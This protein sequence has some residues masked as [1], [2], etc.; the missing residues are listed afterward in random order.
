MGLEPDK[1]GGWQPVD[2]R[3]KI[4]SVHASFSWTAAMLK[5]RPVIANGLLEF[6]EPMFT[7][8]YGFLAVKTW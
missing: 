1:V 3:D 6:V 4:K 5:T 7:A 8:I 2:W